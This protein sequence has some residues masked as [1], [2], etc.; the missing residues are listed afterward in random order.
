M[1]YAVEILPYRLRAKGTIGGRAFSLGGRVADRIRAGFNIFNFAISLSLI[2]NQYVNP[3]AF[4]AMGWKYYA[5]LSSTLAADGTLT[6]TTAARL[7][8]VDRV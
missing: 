5:S 6:C 8:R 2:F 7:C 1:T 4:D 3:I